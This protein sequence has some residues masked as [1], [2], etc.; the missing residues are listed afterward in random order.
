V[1]FCADAERAQGEV[2]ELQ[3][4]VLPYAWSVARSLRSRGFQLAGTGPGWVEL[5]K[6]APL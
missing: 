3:C 1:Y 6:T 4:I 5:G 2:S